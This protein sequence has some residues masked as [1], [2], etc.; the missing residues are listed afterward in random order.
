MF[1][2]IVKCQEHRDGTLAKRSCIEGNNYRRLHD[3]SRTDSSSIIECEENPS[4]Q[5]PYLE[6]SLLKPERVGNEAAPFTT[7]AST[8]LNMRH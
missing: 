7:F 5:L 3:Y 1:K 6:R 4:D 2:A 8:V